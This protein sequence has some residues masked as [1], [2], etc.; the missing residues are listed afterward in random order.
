MDEI[1]D[2]RKWGAVGDGIYKNT[3]IIQRCLDEAG[4]KG[5]TVYVGGGG[6]YVCGTLYLPSDVTIFIG[7]G[8][9]LLAS[10]DISDYGQDTH[11]NRYRNEKDLDRC[12][13]YGCDEENIQIMGNGV[14]DGKCNTS[15]T[16]GISGNF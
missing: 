2:I 9:R 12:W 1:I 16:Y 14:L 10:P 8:T 4:Q 13:L 6:T 3:K 11:H 5:G 7:G 15:G